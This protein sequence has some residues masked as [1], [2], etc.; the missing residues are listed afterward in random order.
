MHAWKDARDHATTIT[1]ANAPI[2]LQ[3]IQPPNG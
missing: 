2:S 1:A 3:M